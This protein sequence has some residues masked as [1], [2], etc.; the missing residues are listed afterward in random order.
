MLN[1]FR[2]KS[3]SMSKFLKVKVAAEQGDFSAMIQLWDIYRS[4][5]FSAT[6]KEIDSLRLSL[7]EGGHIP[8][9][10]Y[11]A[12]CADSQ[13]PSSPKQA[14]KWYTIAADLGNTEAAYRAGYI[15][16]TGNTQYGLDHDTTDYGTE[17][18]AC[19]E[20]KANLYFSKAAQDKHILACICMSESL[21]STNQDGA[22][23]YLLTAQ[24]ATKTDIE[25]CV[26]SQALGNYYF[27]RSDYA[28]ASVYLQKA[29]Q[30]EP[31]NI[32]DQLRL[33]DCLIRDG[34]AESIASAK[35]QLK[36]LQQEQ[37][38]TFQQKRVNALL[39]QLPEPVANAVNTLEIV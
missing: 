37:L 28:Q 24:A 6:E 36:I 27:N 7:A 5:Q 10:L 20:T 15:L 21:F 31:N 9:V 32:Y 39:K 19:D 22:L 25:R 29:C 18:V 38:S 4:K 26:V 1:F 13:A 2:K 17:A 34:S 8:A 16:S 23:E 3:D 33:V 35:T 30:L 11:Y 14:L 12:E